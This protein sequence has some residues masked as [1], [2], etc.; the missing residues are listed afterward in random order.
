MTGD[1]VEQDAQLA[2]AIQF[3]RERA[4]GLP[5]E[6]IEEF[7]ALQN[8]WKRAYPDECISWYRDLKRSH[9]GS[10]T[11]LYMYGRI[12]NNKRKALYLAREAITLEPGWPYGYRLLMGTYCSCLYHCECSRKDRHA[13]LAEIPHDA[14]YFE[15]VYENCPDA[16]KML[17]YVFDYNIFN[18]KIEGAKA[19]VKKARKL[20]QGW[21]QGSDVMMVIKAA[22]NNEKALRKYIK[23]LVM[24]MEYEGRVD[25]HERDA[26]IVDWMARYYRAAFA[27]SRALEL[28]ARRLPD[29]PPEQRSGIYFDMA[30]YST[31]LEEDDLA[32]KYLEQAVNSGF[33][34]VD[35]LE[36]EDDFIALHDD[37][38]WEQYLEGVKQNWMLGKT[39][40]RQEALFKKVRFV[41]PEFAMKDSSGNEITHN[42][43]AGSV[44]VLDFWSTMC[45]PCQKALP[46]I[47]EFYREDRRPGVNVYCVNLWDQS[48]S[49]VV[50][51]MEKRGYAIPVAFGS[52]TMKRRFEVNSVPQIFIIDPDGIIRFHEAGYKIGLRE[53]LRWWTEDLLERQR[54]KPA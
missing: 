36:Q 4:E 51:W 37:P 3:C 33:D 42:D 30:R 34:R 8:M 1:H 11:H 25:P 24:Q 53:R 45:G 49:Y 48:P 29:A 35:R 41:M 50:S 19:V 10:A 7:R 9:P 12:V 5:D 17:H 27:F 6:E 2:H 54:P 16:G 23:D 15:H 20:K 14:K 46:E 40:R 18:R 13:L 38:R 22:E 44:T 21:A 28:L 47:D 52:E 43:L 32:F 26:N 39:E 31:L